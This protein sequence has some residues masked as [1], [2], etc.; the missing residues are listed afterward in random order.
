MYPQVHNLLRAFISMP[1]QNNLPALYSLWAEWLRE[2]FWD[3]TKRTSLLFVRKRRKTEGSP[4][5]FPFPLFSFCIWSYFHFIFSSFSSVKPSRWGTK[6][7]YW[8][9]LWRKLLIWYL[10]LLLYGFFFLSFYICPV[11]P[12]VLGYFC[13]GFLLSFL[14]FQEN[15]PLEEVFQTLRCNKNGLTTEAAHE[16]LAIFGQNKLE[17]KKVFFFL[18][19]LLSLIVSLF[20]FVWSW[21]E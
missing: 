4:T 20:S 8:K 18:S 16:R 1:R 5:L 10:N 9:L 11:F 3:N 21:K 13:F 17:E 7:K 6:M 14:N 15:V 2:K 12:C 19:S